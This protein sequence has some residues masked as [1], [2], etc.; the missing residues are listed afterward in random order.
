MTKN[1][2]YVVCFYQ[3]SI[4]VYYIVSYHKLNNTT[5]SHITYSTALQSYTTSHHTT[6]HYI[7]SNH[8]STFVVSHH[9]FITLHHITPHQIMLTRHRHFTPHH[10]T[11]SS[12]L[13]R[14]TH[15]TF[16]TQH[17]YLHYITSSPQHNK[18][19][20]NL[21]TSQHNLN[22]TKHN[23]TS[24][25]HN[26]NPTHHNTTSTQH[27][28]NTTQHT[29]FLQHHITPHLITSDHAISHLNRIV[30]DSYDRIKIR[31]QRDNITQHS[32]N[33]VIFKQINN[34]SS[35][36]CRNFSSSKCSRTSTL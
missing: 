18:T 1:N 20:H 25:Q 21:N 16:T 24:T 13:R 5:S 12:H 3:A 2:E 10:T 35:R 28:L 32:Q 26:L 15:H 27:N 22:T 34:S 30:I 8:T 23:T 19:Q 6:T 31:L 9:T 29:I 7:T 17:L 33:S 4:R 11:L 36:I 14:I